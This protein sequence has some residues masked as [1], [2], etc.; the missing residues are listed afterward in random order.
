MMHASWKLPSRV[1]SFALVHP[2][3]PWPNMVMC[4][5]AASPCGELDIHLLAPEGSQGL[6]FE[7]LAACMQ[8]E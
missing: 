5:L 3:T 6:A 4:S 1:C 7:G 8:R 2:A